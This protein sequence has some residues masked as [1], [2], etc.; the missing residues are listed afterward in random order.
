MYRI[1]CV[2][3]HPDDEAAN[4][5]GTLARL[6]EQGHQIYLVCLTSGEAARNRGTAK[7]NEE[8]M[9]L[10]AQELAASCQLLGVQRHDIWRYPDGGLQ[11][12]DFY[13]AVGRLVECIR[14]WRPQVVLTMGP[15]G[16]V[17]GHPDHSMVSLMA[18]AAYHWAA[19]ERHYPGQKLQPWQ[20]DRL[21][22]ATAIARPE[23]FLD[24][25]LPPAHVVVDI[26][27]YLERKIAAFKLHATQAGLFER[28]EQ[29]IRR[30]NGTE[31]F[32]LASAP[33]GFD[34]A[35]LHNDL[36]AGLGE[37]GAE[38]NLPQDAGHPVSCSKS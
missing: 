4:F 17:T 36:L 2:T 16:A 22:Y 6:S 10:R 23:G 5:G 25:H 19:Q 18:T 24:V 7:T 27:P 38:D 12:V 15:E 28:V 9:T 3:A 1:F 21:F 37:P 35:T 30:H 14:Q 8:L 11:R 34:L 29:F 33:M 31:R 13:E 32:H 26:E 20:A